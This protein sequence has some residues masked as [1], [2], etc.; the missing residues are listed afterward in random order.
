MYIQIG[1]R[2]RYIF[3]LWSLRPDGILPNLEIGIYRGGQIVA[4]FVA[5]A[6]NG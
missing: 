6:I 4:R 2:G 5:D 3:G 1:L